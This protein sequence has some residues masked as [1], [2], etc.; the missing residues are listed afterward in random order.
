LEER[1]CDVVEAKRLTESSALEQASAGLNDLADQERAR[2]TE[3]NTAYVGKLGFPFIITMRD[4]TR[5]GILAAFEA[6]LAD[7]R[8]TEFDTACRTVE[9]IAF[10]RL[11]AM[12]PA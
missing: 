1:S 6:R 11:S 8:D 4:N 10:P 2:F 3:L 9:R 5:A 12:L 7:D